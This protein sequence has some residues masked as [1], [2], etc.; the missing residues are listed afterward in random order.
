MAQSDTK[1]FELLGQLA[2]QGASVKS[3]EGLDG[4]ALTADALRHMDSPNFEAW[5][6]WNKSF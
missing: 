6:T 1:V 4:S 2:D 3:G 5:I